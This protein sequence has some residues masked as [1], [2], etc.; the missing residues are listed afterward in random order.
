MLRRSVSV[1]TP[2]GL[3]VSPPGS[4]GITARPLCPE[5]QPAGARRI[6]EK[7]SAWFVITSTRMVR[8][9][10]SSSTDLWP[11]QRRTNV[12]PSRRDVDQT[13]PPQHRQ[14]L[15]QMGRLDADLRQ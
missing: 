2:A 12:A 14:L 3:K 9:T 10:R 8:A 15:R 13:H 6:I 1:T 5:G 7:D 11:H 4:S